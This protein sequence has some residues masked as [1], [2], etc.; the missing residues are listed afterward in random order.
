MYGKLKS[1]NTSHTTAAVT[2]E[3]VDAVMVS[4]QA[5]IG[6]VAQS[7]IEVEDRVTLPQLRVLVLVASRGTMNLSAVAA[8]LDV[9]PSNATRACARLTKAGLLTRQASTIDRRNYLVSLT[10]DGHA[11][12]DTLVE[13]RRQAITAV[14]E[15]VPSRRRG[16]LVSAVRTFSQAAGESSADE[17]AKLGWT[18]QGR[19]RPA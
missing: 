3:Q 18:H 6:V 15:R 10:A 5:L 7:V 1:V 14:L 4:A 12:I 17:A 16:A 9:H 8:A 11:L 2:A 19:G 13:H